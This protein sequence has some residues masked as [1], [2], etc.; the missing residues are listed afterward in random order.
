MFGISGINNTSQHC[1][2]KIVQH[3]LLDLLVEN[4]NTWF[5]MYL[6]RASKK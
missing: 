5:T 2:M 3:V 1:Q 4:V 6:R